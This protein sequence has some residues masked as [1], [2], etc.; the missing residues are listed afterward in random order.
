MS[1]RIPK[2]VK[3]ARLKN[4]SNQ[5]GLNMQGNGNTIGNR[6]M[7]NK[8]INKRVNTNTKI[9]CVNNGKLTGKMAGFRNGK[10]ICVDNK[11]YQLI[12]QAPRSRACAGGVGQIRNTRCVIQNSKISSQS[13]PEP[14]D[15]WPPLRDIM[16]LSSCEFMWTHYARQAKTKSIIDLFKWD[17]FVG[18]KYVQL[19]DSLFF[20][21][22]A[23]IDRGKLLAMNPQ[24]LESFEKLATSFIDTGHVNW[25]EAFGQLTFLFPPTISVPS[26]FD[27]EKRFFLKDVNILSAGQR[28][29]VTPI[30][31]CVWLLSNAAAGFNIILEND[32]VPDDA[33][34][35]GKLWSPIMPFGTDALVLGFRTGFGEG[36][37][38]PKALAPGA[39]RLGKHYFPY[40]S[41]NLEGMINNMINI[42]GRDRKEFSLKV[43]GLSIIFKL[44][45]MSVEHLA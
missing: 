37:F 44:T 22:T 17:G 36:D 25:E 9:G 45:I 14:E 41:N 21:T 1:G 40:I 43:H 18:I 29:I 31:R 5:I 30:V 13:E 11:N 27:P 42:S 10:Q 34:S 20:T 2:R 23:D 8:K 32:D 15:K 4:N 3:I 26:T 28:Y 38:D 24:I 6:P 16:N 33:V 39:T 7:I 35:V 12:P 19:P